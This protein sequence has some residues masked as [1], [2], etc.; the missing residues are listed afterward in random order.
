[1][2]DIPGEKI[3]WFPLLDVSLRLDKLTNNETQD[4]KGS[5]LISKE[6]LAFQLDCYRKKKS[7]MLVP[8]KLNRN[9]V[10]SLSLRSVLHAFTISQQGEKRQF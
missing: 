3:I 6:A 2:Y 9:E 8:D 1:M 10:R 7:M 5:V 4:S